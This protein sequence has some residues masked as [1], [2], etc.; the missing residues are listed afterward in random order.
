MANAGVD[1][2]PAPD[3]T[4]SKIIVITG[5]TGGIGYQEALL[6]AAEAPKHTIVVTG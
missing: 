4:K 2:Y 6:L 5:G 3:P 1:L